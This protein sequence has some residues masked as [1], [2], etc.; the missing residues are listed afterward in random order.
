[1][2]S[3]LGGSMFGS[4]NFKKGDVT[5]I[6]PTL[7]QV[8]QLK[9][10]ENNKDTCITIQCYM[11]DSEDVQHHDTF[12]YLDADGTEQHFDPNSDMD[13]VKFKETIK[14]EWKS[15]NRCTISRLWSGFKRIF[16]RV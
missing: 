16:K 1:M 14:A 13:F 10:L 3:F 2:F 6:S 9:N 5:W 8:H 12:D 11:Y 7:N 15:A 4:A